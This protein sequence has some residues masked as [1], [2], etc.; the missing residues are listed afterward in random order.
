M[1]AGGSEEGQHMGNPIEPGDY[2][3]DTTHSQIGF[4]VQHLG[5]TPVRGLFTGYRGR[6]LVADLPAGSS[7]EVTVDV[8]TVQSGNAG[9]DEHLQVADYF[10][11]ANHPTM[12]YRSTG[13][14]EGPSGWTVDGE[15]TLKGTT[16][17]L[18]LQA[19]VTGRALFPLDQKEHIG[20]TATGHLHRTAFGI[21]PDVP[22]FLLSDV[23]QLEL[24][25]QLLLP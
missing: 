15:L 16:R 23:I 6:L 14:V 5:L 1:A 17:P 20:V 12:T 8:T 25:V 18:S 3:F 11:S 19:A 13:F 9:R 22:A 24:A 7:L 10:D 2:A 21:G 4:S